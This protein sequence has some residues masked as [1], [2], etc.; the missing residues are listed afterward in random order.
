MNFFIVERGDK[1]TYEK[2]SEYTGMSR[3]SSNNGLRVNCDASNQ[4]FSMVKVESRKTK[5][6]RV[7]EIEVYTFGNSSLQSD[8][9]LIYSGL[10]SLCDKSQILKSKS[11]YATLCNGL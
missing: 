5:G 1:G 4:M 9:T 3:S 6:I 11:S 2:C 8:I 10:S 7:A